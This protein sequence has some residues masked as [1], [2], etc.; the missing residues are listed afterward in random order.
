[1]LKQALALTRDLHTIGMKCDT[2]VMDTARLL[3]IKIQDVL[4][5]LPTSLLVYACSRFLKF[6]LHRTHTF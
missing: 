4:T 1:M 2:E 5:R 6:N 3:F